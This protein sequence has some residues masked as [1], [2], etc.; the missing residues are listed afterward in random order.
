MQ[1]QTQCMPQDCQLRQQ[2]NTTGMLLAAIVDAKERQRKRA[3]L[4]QAPLEQYASQQACPQYIGARTMPVA[5]AAQYGLGTATIRPVS[6]VTVPC[7]YSNPNALADV[8][9]KIETSSTWPVQQMVEAPHINHGFALAKTVPEEE[10][11]SS[12]NDGEEELLEC[13]DDGESDDLSVPT[14]PAAKGQTTLMVRNVP[15]MY[16][17]EMLIEEWPNDGSYDFLYL[18]RSGAGRWNLSYAFINFESEAQAVKFKAQ[19]QKKRLAHFSAK[20]PLN[21]SFA[22]VQGLEA[23]LAQ[24]K[25]KRVRWQSHFVVATKGQ[26]APIQQARP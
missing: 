6:Y 23:N 10:E 5:C 18:P 2:S 16:T 14:E 17:Q 11:Q 1:H 19:W 3:Q 25:K 7:G 26:E 21:I 15:V 8:P 24:L 20:K 4:Q 9:W 12:T 22:E 13:T